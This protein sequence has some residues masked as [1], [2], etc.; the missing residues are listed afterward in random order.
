MASLFWAYFDMIWIKKFPPDY[1]NIFG[2][3]R[4][5]VNR[6]NSPLERYHRELNARIPT[7]HPA[8]DHFI[9]TIEELARFYVVSR[10]SIIAVQAP[11]P[12]RPGMHFPRALPTADMIKGSDTESEAN[13]D[14]NALGPEGEPIGSDLNVCDGSEHHSGDEGEQGPPQYDATFDY[15][16]EDNSIADL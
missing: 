6:T 3:Q 5:I 14:S 16:G 2:M 8:L 1:W 7:P 11:R 12:E 9:Q 15:D 13:S 10:K 4:K